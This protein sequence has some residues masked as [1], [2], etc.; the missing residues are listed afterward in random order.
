MYNK[1]KLNSK[2]YNQ[3]NNSIFKQIN[4]N[5]ITDYQ[6][7]MYMAELSQNQYNSNICKNKIPSN[8]NHNIYINGTIDPD[9]NY[10]SQDDKAKIKYQN[11]IQGA[12]KTEGEKKVR[13]GDINE[14]A[15]Q[16]KG[17]CCG[18]K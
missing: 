16:K 8:K 12:N 2:N 15:N 4:T 3:D 9:Y 11:K 6:K 1:I 7:N 10:K 14:N 18:G 13:L 5:I 17:G